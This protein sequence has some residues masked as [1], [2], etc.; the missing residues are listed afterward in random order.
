MNSYP[1]DRADPSVLAQKTEAVLNGF[2]GLQTALGNPHLPKAVADPASFM[3]NRYNAFQQTVIR[4]DWLDAAVEAALAIA[5]CG[6]N[7]NFALLASPSFANKGNAEREQLKNISEDL[8][9]YCEAH[10]IDVTSLMGNPTLTNAPSLNSDSPEKNDRLLRDVTEAQARLETTD[11]QMLAMEARL[12]ALADTADRAVQRVENDVSHQSEVVRKHLEGQLVDLERRFSDALRAVS[13]RSEH[14]V[15]YEKKAE[16]IL[17]A[18]ANRVLSH[19]YAGSAGKEERSADI[20]RGLSIVL[21]FATFVIL[22]HTLYT[23]AASPA[24]WKDAVVRIIISLIIAVPT[25]YLAREAGKHRAQSIELRRTSLD[26]LALTPYLAEVQEQS[27]RDA[28]KVELARRVF[29]GNGK[30]D[31]STSFPLD[32]QALANKVINLTAEVVKKS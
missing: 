6:L 1:T 28:I 11:R 31:S 25:G 13:E 29:F 16:S 20:F 3:A 4:E 14:F 18:M 9:N 26:F 8:K 30:A 17:D 10:A 23:L 2:W 15:V 19:G 12:K 21:M 22:S 32:V 5:N 27:A 24:D 7:I